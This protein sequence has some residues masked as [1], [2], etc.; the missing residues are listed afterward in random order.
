MTNLSELTTLHVGGP[1]QQ[2]VRVAPEKELIEAVQSADSTG[3]P[4][5]IIG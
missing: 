3:T 2:V 4:L 5:L 1:A